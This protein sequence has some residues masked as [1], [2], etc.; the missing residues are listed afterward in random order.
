MLFKNEK[1]KDND[2]FSYANNFQVFF[3][4]STTI[5]LDLNR[6]ETTVFDLNI[7]WT[8]ASV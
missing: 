1:K 4:Y 7:D 5:V 2:L 8:R 3:F 6:F